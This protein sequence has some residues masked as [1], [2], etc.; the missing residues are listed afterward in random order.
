LFYISNIGIL[1]G[2]AAKDESVMGGIQQPIHPCN[3]RHLIPFEENRG[4]SISTEESGERHVATRE[5]FLHGIDVY[6][7]YWKSAERRV[8]LWDILTSDPYE[9]HIV[10]RRTG[11]H[12][13]ARKVT[14]QSVDESALIRSLEIYELDRLDFAEAYL[15]AQAEA[16]GVGEILSFDG[17][18]DRLTTVRRLER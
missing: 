5:R 3:E 7:T 18:I 10:V 14:E 9:R 13:E 8:S 12:R 1:N 16:T 17:S 4:R 6:E 15:A 11:I 2:V